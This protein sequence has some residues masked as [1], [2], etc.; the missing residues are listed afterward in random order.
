MIIII[1]TVFVYI[2]K[3]IKYF[4]DDRF[5]LITLLKYN[6]YFKSNFFI[7]NTATNAPINSAII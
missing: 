7:N 6:V 3:L 2:E 4:K 5:I 1:I